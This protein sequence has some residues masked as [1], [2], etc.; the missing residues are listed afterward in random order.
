M[1]NYK[2]FAKN[3]LIGIEDIIVNR[4]I[5]LALEES[6]IKLQKVIEKSDSKF[7]TQTIDIQKIMFLA[8]FGMLLMR[9]KGQENKTLY[10]LFYGCILAAFLNSIN[11]Y[12]YIHQVCYPEDNSYDFLIL[13]IPS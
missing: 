4:V 5:P 9:E 7:Y 13:E 10:E 11:N 6:F 8:S 3:P 2:I 12:N 1:E